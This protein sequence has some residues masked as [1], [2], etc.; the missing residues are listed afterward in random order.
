MHV[1]SPAHTLDFYRRDGCH[2]CDEARESLQAALEERARRGDPAVRIRVINLSE[3]PELEQDFG[4]RI[5]VIAVGSD[6]LSLVTSERSIRTFLD[7]VLGR[8]A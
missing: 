2:L 3:Q 5:P 7:R 8:L 4:A 1:S 6:E